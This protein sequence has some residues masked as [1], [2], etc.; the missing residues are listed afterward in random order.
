MKKTVLTIISTAILIIAFAQSDNNQFKDQGAVT[1]EEVV[2]FDIHLDNMTPEMAEMLPN[3]S[4]STK[5]LYFNKHA[6]RYENFEQNDDAAI[7][8]EE[9][10]SGMKIMISQPDNIVYMDFESGKMTEQKEFMTRVFLIE[11]DFPKDEWKFTGNQKMILNYP[12][13]EATKLEG[14]DLVSVWFTPAIPV[15]TGPGEYGNLP[16]LIL[17]VEAN[18]G[19]RTIT[20]KSIDFEEVDVK[21]LQKPKKGKKVSQEEYLAIVEE[22]NE[23]MGGKAGGGKTMIMTISR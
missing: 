13:Q 21:K 20:A 22:K 11:S 8:H 3:E 7:E 10:G 9:G 23:E 17:A 16:G 12:C 6:S 4:R 14:E 2:K 18:D 5:R 19:D 15:S 1:Y